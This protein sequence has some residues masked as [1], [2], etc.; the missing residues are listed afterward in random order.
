MAALDVQEIAADIQ[1]I[2]HHLKVERDTWQTIATRYKAAFEAQTARLEELQGICFATQAELDNERSQHRRLQYSSDGSNRRYPSIIDGAEDFKASLSYGTA[3]ILQNRQPFGDCTNP[4]FHRATQCAEQHNYG[5]AI[6]EVE[7]LLRG[8]LSPKA[9]AEGLLL[10]SSVLKA[11]GPDELYNSLAACSEALELCDR[12]SELESFLP[13]IQYQ[14][15]VL[16]YQLRMLH[17]ARD[18]FTAV[19]DNTLSATAKD[20]R[21]SCD[22]E[23][24]LLRAENRRSGFDES[25][26]FDEGLLVQLDEKLD[27]CHTQG[28]ECI[29]LTERRPS[30]VVLAHSCVFELPSSPSACPFPIAGQVAGM[31]QCLDVF[32]TVRSRGWYPL[33][34][35]LFLYFTMSSARSYFF[36]CSLS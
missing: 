7:R 22:D 14:R 13:R 1:N 30:V 21:N 5:S 6:I 35:S 31:T 23:I 2:V 36:G 3:A 26:S 28:T 29:V 32:Q 18:A 25:R 8:P 16:Y 12:I 20:Y 10:K 11:A 4:L 19:D 24:R 33:K 27:V 9:R 17:Q 15:G 34:Y